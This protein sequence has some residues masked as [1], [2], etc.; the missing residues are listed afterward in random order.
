MRHLLR[1]AYD[2][3][4]FAG[5]CEL[6]D[7]RTVCGVLRQALERVNAEPGLIETLSRTDAGVH[8]RG[9]VG[10]V[11]LGRTM[12]DADL[13]A[14][15]D[16][17]LPEDL[18][19]TGV[20]S[21]D[22][23]PVQGPKLY[24]YTLDTSPHGDPLAARFTWRPASPVGA[25]VLQ[26]LAA[27]LVGTRDWVAFRRTGETRADLVRTI[28]AA[29]WTPGDGVLHFTI[30]GSGFPYRLV[31]SLVGGM[32]AVARGGATRE[33][34]LGALDGKE[35]AAA[36]QTAPARGLTL[37]ESLSGVDWVA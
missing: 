7:Q 2:G 3:T 22:D 30:S 31:R 23:G 18:R 36:T 9:N 16:R 5:C 26:D 14:V 15:L 24:R 11:E 6:P 12:D 25:G 21:V 37:L 19:C 1:L 10:H 32:V 17:H 29:T 28:R 8:A 33:D 13:L 27:P 35:T 34:W 4:G 20:A